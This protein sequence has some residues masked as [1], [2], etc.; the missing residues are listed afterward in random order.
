MAKARTPRTR[1][2]EAGFDAL[3]NGGPDAVRIEPLAKALAVT[4]GGF[5]WY[6]DDREALL[7]ELLSTWEHTLV[8]EVIE[9]I[10]RDGGDARGKLEHLFELAES[11]EP[12]GLMRVELAIRDWARRDEGVRARLRQVDNRRTE[13]LRGLYAQ[14]CEGPDDVEARCLMTMALFVGS[15]FIAAD[16]GARSRAEVVNHALQRLLR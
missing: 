9:Q 2:I 3:A 4:K 7:E 1:W 6:F 13:Y 10:E 14:F 15:R 8:D 5:Y 16:H 11:A 12:R